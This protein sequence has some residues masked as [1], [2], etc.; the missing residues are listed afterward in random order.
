MFSISKC[1]HSARKAKSQTVC[2]FTKSLRPRH[3]SGF[4][5]LYGFEEVVPI[6][7]KTVTEFCNDLSKTSAGPVW[8]AGDAAI[9][10]CEAAGKAGI[11]EVQAVDDHVRLPRPGVVGLVGMRMFREGKVVSPSSAVPEYYRRS[12]AEVVFAQKQ[13]KGDVR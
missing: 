3:T 8:V 2:G 1:G 5:S 13:T 12:Q 11:R 9:E 6:C 10:F 4:W 7:A